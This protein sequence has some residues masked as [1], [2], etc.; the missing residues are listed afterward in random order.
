MQG[1]AKCHEANVGCALQKLTMPRMEEAEQAEV[2]SLLEAEEDALHTID[3]AI[4]NVKKDDEVRY[5]HWHR[6][7]YCCTWSE[8]ENCAQPFL[9][10]IKRQIHHRGQ[11][12]KVDIIAVVGRGFVVAVQHGCG[13]HA[14]E[15]SGRGASPRAGV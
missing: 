8:Q 5:G 4:E 15:T 1:G 13:A 11:V 14:G 6:G 2:A 12:D 3:S 10:P 9:L 7:E